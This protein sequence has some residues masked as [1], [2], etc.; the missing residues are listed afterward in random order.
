MQEVLITGGSGFFGGVLKRR[1]LAEGF[2]CVN[3]DLVPDHDRHEKL[4]SIQGDLRDQSLLSR[5]FA[6][7][8]FAAVFHC[9]AMLA[10]GE[11][12]EKHLWS[13]NVD[14]T[15]NVA[16]ACRNFGVPTLVFTSTNCLWG[17]NLG[18]AVA[19][20]EPPKPI[21]VYG[22]SKLAGEEALACY[23]DSINVIIFRCPTIIDS[24]RLGLLAIL[25]EF[26]QDGKKVWVVGGGANRYQFI[27]AQDLANACLLAMN[28]PY[29]DTFHIGSDD[30]KPLRAV[31]DAV[32]TAAKSKSRIASLPK[33]P[34]IAAMKLAHKLGISPL[35]PYHY[36]M[37]AEDFLF[38]TA[39][40][41]T[42]LGWRPTLTNEEMLVR[43]YQYYAAQRVEIYAR[44]DVSAHSKPAAMGI[45][46]LLKWIS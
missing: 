20:N 6:S 3:L 19:E 38:E 46:R 44:R 43:A 5:T 27:Y 31:Y 18:H 16:E 33:G 41:K 35:G 28:Y 45:I 12:D 14:G 2:R 21:E 1:L 30:V 42:K 10:H 7:H 22:R 25:F 9:A 40:I 26:I 36:Q 11:M 23:R 37:I 39:K 29:S 24:G 17:S 34:A 15:R 32:I 4:E 8:K 13:S